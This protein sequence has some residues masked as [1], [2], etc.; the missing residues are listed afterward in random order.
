[1]E[2]EGDKNAGG[3]VSAPQIVV[4]GEVE[5]KEDP[6]SEASATKKGSEKIIYGKCARGHQFL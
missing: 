5:G 4:N 1:M 3:D 2:A 6:N